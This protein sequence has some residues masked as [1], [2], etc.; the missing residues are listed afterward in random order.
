ME[1]A[2]IVSSAERSAQS[3]AT[4]LSEFGIISPV[5]FANGGDARRMVDEQNFDVVVISTPL[6]DEY[7]SE[8]AAYISESTT[9]GVILLVKAENADEVSQKVESSGVFVIGTP[10]S[11]TI[12][13]H[14][15]RLA[16]AMENRLVMLQKE[17]IKL[18]KKIQDI[19][20][21]DRAKYVLMQCLK[22]GEDDAHHYMEKQA[23]D[24]RCTK[25][26][27]AKNIIRTYKN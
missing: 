22:M 19:R 25:V 7:G 2:L 6:R 4:L 21:I 23:M 3:I 20:P 11:R 18:Q 15:I 9:M 1:S 13:N 27:V 10:V 8:L 24:L 17:N 26:E 16:P 12:F 5:L 14:T